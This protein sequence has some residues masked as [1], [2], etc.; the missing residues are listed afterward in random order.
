[1]SCDITQIPD[2][3]KKAAEAQREGRMVVPGAV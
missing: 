2:A 3:L 1:M